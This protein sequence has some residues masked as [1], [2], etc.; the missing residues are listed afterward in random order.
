MEFLGMTIEVELWQWIVSQVFAFLALVAV[1]ICFQ[2]KNKVHTLIWLGICN[3]FYM[4]SVMF[5]AN[6]I[7]AVI[8]AIAMLRSFV[9]AW[10]D[11]R[12]EPV[13]PKAS[14]AVMFGFMFALVLF[15][16]FMMI[17]LDWWWI[18]LLLLASSIFIIYGNWAKG[19]HIL[20]ISLLAY[21]ALAIINHIFYLNAIAIIVE[22]VAILSIMIFYVRYFI[23][24]NK[25][26]AKEILNTSEEII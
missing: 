23:G 19:I 7:I 26:E 4:I 13:N 22:A 18:D 15:T 16:V 2:L 24:K 14:L 6:W 25:D 9:F 10:I 5:L 12:K 17:Y 1:V 8:V 21:A 20:R 11:S 3:A